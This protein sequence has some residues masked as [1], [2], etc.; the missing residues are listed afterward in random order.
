MA[1]AHRR[2]AL[3]SVARMLE[4]EPALLGGSAHLLAVAQRP[5]D[6]STD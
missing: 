5:T 1:D 6:S 2:D 4:A 3:L